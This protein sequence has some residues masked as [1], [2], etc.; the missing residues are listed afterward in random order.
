[1]SEQP[2]IMP[3]EPVRRRRR[4]LAA[5]M[6]ELE[7][8]TATPLAGR[9]EAWSGAV[10]DVLGHLD[11][12]LAAHV[13]ATERAGGLLASVREEEPALDPLVRRLEREHVDLTRRTG[14]ARAALGPAG[15]DEQRLADVRDRVTEL[16]AELARHRQRGADLLY[17]A[18]QVDLGGGG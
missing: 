6:R 8:V 13:E 5:V 4:A 12:V 2:V 11:V 1:M 10:A 9:A 15:S 16:L 7:G 14:E 18:Y 3:F 17:Q